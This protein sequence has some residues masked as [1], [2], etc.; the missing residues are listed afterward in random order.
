MKTNKRTGCAGNRGFVLIS[1]YLV[2]VVL[3]LIAL[4]FFWRHWTFMDAAER[5]RNKIAA[6]N[7]AEAAVDTAMVELTKGSS[8]TDTSYGGTGGYVSKDT[9]DFKG[10]YSIQVCPP[11]CTGLTQPDDGTMRLVLATGY[12]PSN[13]SQD[14]GYETRSVLSHIKLDK[15]STFK[16]AVFAKNTMDLTGNSGVDSFD[17]GEGVYDPNSP[18]T[19]GDIGT[20]STAE[21]AINLNGSGVYVK[22]DAFVGP[23]GDPSVV[24]DEGNGDKITGETSAMQKTIN[25]QPITTDI[26]ASGPLSLTG[27]GTKAD[28]V[29]LT[30]GTY[31]Y[32]SLKINQDARLNLLG[33]VTIYVDGDIDIGGNGVLTYQNLPQNLVIYATADSSGHSKDAV[34]LSGGASFYGAIYAPLADVKNTGNAEVTGSVVCNN[35]YQHGTG[36]GSS[37]IHFDEALLQIKNGPD[38]TADVRSW[39]EVN[40]TVNG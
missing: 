7:M 33:P 30:A 6:F 22:G 28:V 9:T 4:A 15:S 29:D 5:N 3:S 18:G 38:V 37:K 32:T 17:S 20:N 12:A 14:R 2:I 21:D 11:A 10:G 13:N 8:P 27:Q 25:Y 36:Q 23:G 1:A 31:H 24:I 35:Y 39:R 34:T 19:N 40:K 16:H 26:H